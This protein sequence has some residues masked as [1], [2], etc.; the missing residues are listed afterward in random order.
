MAD[1][2]LL[3][4]LA[5][6]WGSP[7]RHRYPEGYPRELRERF[8][9]P[10]GRRVRLRAIRPDDAARLRDGFAKLSPQTVYRR[11]HANLQGLSDEALR[12]LT[13]LDY[14]DHL[15]LIALDEQGDA[16]G[17]ARYYRPEAAELAEAAVVVGDPWQGQ[18]VG[19][20]LLRALALAAEQRGIVGFEGFVQQDNQ[21]MRRMVERSGFRLHADDPEDGVIRFWLRFDDLL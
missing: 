6:R 20:H 5:R 19:T 12:Y 8:T 9:T 16:V 1:S 21:V 7:Q 2:W 4:D 15:A 18:G 13:H 10:D 11:F 14:Q 3:K 17:V